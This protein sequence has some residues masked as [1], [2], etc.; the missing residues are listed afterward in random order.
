MSPD[1]FQL[2]RVVSGLLSALRRSSQPLLSISVATVALC[3]V[4]IPGMRPRAP[5]RNVLVG[6][7]YL[8]VLTALSGLLFEFAF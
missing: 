3:V 8:C 5:K 2:T 4:W 6:L 1:D 7:V